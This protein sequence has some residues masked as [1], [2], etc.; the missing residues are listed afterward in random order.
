VKC[1]ADDIDMTL[2]NVSRD[3]IGPL[4]YDA[5]HHPSIRATI[6][7]PGIHAWDVP[8]IFSTADADTTPAAQYN[9]Q[10]KIKSN[11]VCNDDRVLSYRTD[12]LELPADATGPD[13]HRHQTAHAVSKQASTY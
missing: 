7:R 5:Q 10:V 13:R 1:S 11:R 4:A 8:H 12:A 2:Q 6:V 9:L 3:Y